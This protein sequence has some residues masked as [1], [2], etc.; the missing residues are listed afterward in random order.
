MITQ[1]RHTGLVVADLESALCFWCNLLGFSIVKRMDESG[2]HINAMMGLQD[3]QVTTVKLAAPDGNLIEL[4]HFNSHPDKPAWTGT[5]YSTGFTHIALTVDDL[6]FVCQ[7]LTDAGVI[8]NT[9]PQ[10]SP[11]GYAKV[12]Y[13]RGP[14]GVLLELVE[15]LQT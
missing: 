14:E 8:F 7:K 6:D 13:G 11:D 4:L 9:L 12:T 10:L 2:P 5:P 3:V 15:V 1:I